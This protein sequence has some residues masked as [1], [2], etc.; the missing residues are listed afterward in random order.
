MFCFGLYRTVA[1]TASCFAFASATAEV[2][3]WTGESTN[4]R[5][6]RVSEN[7]GGRPFP[8]SGDSLVFAGV[9]R[10]NPNNNNQTGLLIS[11]ITFDVTSGSFVLGGSSI[12]LSGEICNNNFILQTVD[13]GLFFTNDCRLNTADG[14]LRITGEI[15]GA[16]DLIK[17]G[18]NTL[19]LE[20]NNSC[21]GDTLVNRGIVALSS[22]DS[23]AQT[24]SLY[25][26]GGTLLE[27]NFSDRTASVGRLYFGTTEQDGGIWGAPGSGAEHESPFFKGSGRLEVR[28]GEQRYSGLSFMLTA[29]PKRDPD[30]NLIPELNFSPEETYPPEVRNYQG[31]PSIE[32]AINGR[33]WA[34]WYCG[35]VG[36]DIYNYV[37]TA[38]SF[39]N[40]ETWSQPV[41]M[42][43]PDGAGPYRACN[44]VF[45]MDPIGKL[46]LFWSQFPNSKAGN[47]KVYTATTQN[48]GAAA[49]NWTEPRVICD[50]ITQNRPV[51]LKSGTWLLPVARWYGAE[52]AMVVASTNQ[53]ASW[54]WI[55]AATVPNPADRSCDE[56][57]I[58]ERNDGSLL[59][60]LRTQYGIGKSISTNSGVCWT[61]VEDTGLPHT[62][63]RFHLSRL[64]SGNLLLIKHGPLTGSPV[65]RKMLTAY[66]SADDGESWSG[67][68]MLDERYVSYPD[69]VQAPD[70]T[71]YSVNDRERKT[72]REIL[73]NRFTETDV[74]SGSSNNPQTTFSILIN[75]SGPKGN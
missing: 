26:T 70:G 68:L 23:I 10:M 63:A 36:E 61:P 22:P 55:G 43:D 21:T 19:F 46:W 13:L 3:T 71:I 7:W 65:G 58:V 30:G 73:M 2:R 72:E 1:I 25:L 74:I 33:L 60:F 66:F 52:S 20:G 57:M 44:P 41:F 53:G 35:P 29:W 37:F 64:L 39:D 45:W 67:G 28:Q 69:A 4:S 11:N 42:I 48:P 5:N 56:P 32:R 40:G 49:P 6:W 50:G 14:A 75:R 9:T 51:V 59:M 24:G 17:I 38:T 15:S 62:P 8:V 12:V 31:V 27:L 16:G 18:E 34:T 54:E 47:S